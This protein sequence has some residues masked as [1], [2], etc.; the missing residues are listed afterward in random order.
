MMRTVVQ[1]VALAFILSATAQ[2]PVQ[3]QPAASPVQQVGTV[4]AERKPVT[5]EASF[6]GRVQAMNRVDILARVTG[7]LDAV[8]FT[9]GE[10]V[11]EGARLFEIEPGP[12]QAAVQ[13][14]D[15][16]VLRAQAQLTNATLQRQR[17][18]ELVKTSALPVAQRD[19]RV[20]AEESAKGQ[21]EIARASLATAK[22]N[23]GYTNITAPIAGR[24][25]RASVTKGNVVGPNNGVLTTIVSVDPTYVVFPV[26][27]RMFLDLER[28]NDS[29]NRDGLR[30]RLRTSDGA[31]YPEVGRINFVDVTVNQSTD[32]VTVRATFANPKGSLVD[33][34][35]LQV[36]V[37]A[38]RPVEK[39]L[40]PQS[41]LIADQA[42]IYVFVVE[43][44]K[45][46]IRRVKMGGEFGADTIVEEG[47]KGGEQVI[48]QGMQTL[49]PGTP[50]Q[51]SPVRPTGGG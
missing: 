21:L 29:T 6:V 47:L 5:R 41:A 22:I 30:V 7:Y 37:E 49:R 24:I 42:G 10:T 19:E 46:E 45:A 40:V 16:E 43:N 28:R 3:A 8:L 15:G 51:A 33:G 35:L 23:L 25:G 11:S 20:A 38:E 4:V 44:G 39:V 36:A 18:D 14:A 2:V 27:A 31:T 32:T 1:S 50:V 26:S 34:Q 13:Q 48:V 17:A 9:E 12:F